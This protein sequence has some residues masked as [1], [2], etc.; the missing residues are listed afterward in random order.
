MGSACWEEGLE[1]VVAEEVRRGRVRAG[2]A[3]GMG[4]ALVGGVP[5]V[6]EGAAVDGAGIGKPGIGRWGNV[7]PGGMTGTVWVV[8]SSRT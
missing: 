5:M 1:P 4:M 8:P 7:V 3:P 2:T 6:V